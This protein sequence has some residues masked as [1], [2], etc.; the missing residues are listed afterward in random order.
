MDKQLTAAL[1]KHTD[2]IAQIE[3]DSAKTIH[4]LSKVV[5]VIATEHG[6]EMAQAN[7]RIKDLEKLNLQLISAGGTM[8]QMTR[9]ALD[10]PTSS[11]VKIQ[12][13]VSA[14]LKA[15]SEH[16]DSLSK[17]LSLSTS[18]ILNGIANLKLEEDGPHSKGG[19]EEDD[20]KYKRSPIDPEQVINL[21]KT[22]PTEE[23][24]KEQTPPDDR[25][26]KSTISG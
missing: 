1:S 14:L 4:H 7:Q 26:G 24:E 5:D 13:D 21:E 23:E 22:P 20:D 25:K 9:Q 15:S 8:V 16:F 19:E 2:R 18:S 10:G 3:E 12:D 17:A 6:K 11:I